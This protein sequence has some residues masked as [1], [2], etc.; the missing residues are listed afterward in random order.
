ML[1]F[2]SRLA[3]R[4]CFALASAL[5]TLSASGPISGAPA[6]NSSAELQGEL[7]ALSKRAQPGTFGIA[8]V[9]LQNGATWGVNAER[10]FPMMSV[11]K[12]PVAAAVLSRV[13]AGSLSLAQ[14]VTVQRS[15]V[16][17]GS[18]VPSIGDHFIGDRMTFTVRRL[19][20]AAVSQSDNTAVDALI[21]LL[22]GG[23]AVTRFLREKGIPAMRVDEDEAAVARVFDHLQGA[24]Q[25]AAGETPAEQDRRLREGYQAFLADPRNTTTPEAAALFLQKLWG[26]QLLSRASTEYLL[27]LMD[28]QTVPNRLRA[29]LPSGV[30]LADKTGTSGTVAGMTAAYNDIGILTWPDGRTVILAA[31]LTGS[32]A[33]QAA[34]DALFAELA[35]T[36]AQAL[37]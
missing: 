15:D 23:Q 37:H 30:R 13:D 3:R 25:P 20:V 11:F 9:D 26:H 7:E 12:A 21:R 24:A 17:P 10:A 19:L 22:G 16:D 29:G 28:A 33:S 36:T 18:A 5:V 31:F 32:A 6:T 35:R 34:R 14:S 4:S 27:Q 1:C 8:V 2:R